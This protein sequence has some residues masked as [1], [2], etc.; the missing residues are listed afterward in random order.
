MMETAGDVITYILDIIKCPSQ[1]EILGHELKHLKV[2]S[3]TE[4]VTGLLESF[5]PV[6]P[7]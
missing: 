1:M 2:H 6:V 7:R 3:C 5:C 4:C